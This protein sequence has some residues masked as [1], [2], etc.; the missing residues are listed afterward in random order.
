MPVLTVVLP[1][2][3]HRLQFDAG[4]SLRDILDTT[5]YRVRSACL[6]LGACGLCRVRVLAGDAGPI[7][8]AERLQLGEEI[9]TGMRLACQYHPAGDVTMELSS[10]A[11]ASD[12]RAP[13]A[14][15]VALETTFP[16]CDRPLLAGIAHPL[17]AAVDLGTSHLT[18]AVVD[19]VTGRILALRFGRNPQGR[20][21]ADIIS[22]LVAA[23]NP[24]VAREL[25]STARAAIGSALADVA[26][27]EGLET[28]RIA[29]VAIVGNTAMLSLLTN[30]NHALL[31]EPAYWSQPVDCAPTDSNEWAQAWGIAPAAEIE[32]VRPLA[33]FVGSDLLAGL[34]VSRLTEGAAPALMVDFGTNSEI[35]LWTGSA[36]WV[37]AA[38]GGPAFEAGAGRGG[39]PAEAGAIY[40]IAFDDGGRAQAAI[41]GDDQ[42]RGLCGSGLVDLVAGLRRKGTLKVT[43]KFAD[44]GEAFR[45]AVGERTLR[46]DWRDVDAL[47]RAKGAIGAGISV[48]CRRAGVALPDLQRVVAAGL[49]GRYLD[50]ANARLIGMLPDVTAQRI[51]LAGNTALTG[52]V[53]LLLSRSALA[54]VDRGR[55][56]ARFVNLAREPSFDEAYLEHLYLQPM[57]S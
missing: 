41:L 32:M 3:P 30:H 45:F 49:F 27:R 1:E 42:A 20:F 31:L 8:A 17:G 29:R 34:A 55:I 35:A 53:A 19:P 5:D 12:W 50:V 11:A 9:A 56:E 38:A 25:A 10:P 28:R 6:G 43:G 4:P 39:M 57:V 37:T 33:G 36:L 2:G 48:L 44:A 46:L 54:A 14:G 15:L 40:R 18:V 52:A 23:E 47:Q 7:T 22:R 21:G 13:P 16:A 24:D 51:E 26:A